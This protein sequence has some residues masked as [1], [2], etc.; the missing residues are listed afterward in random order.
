MKKKKKKKKKKKAFTKSSLRDFMC[1]PVLKFSIQPLSLFLRMLCPGVYF[2]LMNITATS[3]THSAYLYLLRI[4]NC[5]D[6]SSYIIRLIFPFVKPCG[7]GWCLLILAAASFHLYLS[8]CDYSC[9]QCS[10]TDFHP[11]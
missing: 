5:R 11:L 7:H 6:A 1:V 9:L 8:L 10:T 3:F 4:T 2:A